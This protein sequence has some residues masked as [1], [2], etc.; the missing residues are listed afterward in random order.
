M[1]RRPIAFA[2][3]L[4]NKLHIGRYSLGE[5]LSFHSRNAFY[6]PDIII[7]KGKKPYVIIELKDKSSHYK[8]ILNK[9]FIEINRA[10]EY[11]KIEWSIIAINENE[12]YLRRLD[13]KNELYFNIDEIIDIIK[14]SV[15]NNVLFSI[16][17]DHIKDIKSIFDSAI[18]QLSPQQQN[19]FHHFL[20]NLKPTDFI[21]ENE[22]ICF[23]PQKENDFFKS[24]LVPVVEGDI[25]RYTSSNSLFTLLKSCN[26]NMLSLNCMN[27]ISE[28]DY[29]DKYINIETI[30]LDDNIKESNNVFILS[31][32]DESMSDD[33]MMWRLYAQNAEGV[34]LKYHI[35][36]KLI[37]YDYFYL[38][39]VSYGESP[40]SHSVLDFIQKLLEWNY[41]ETHFKFNKWM[42]WKHFFKSYHF[43]YENEVR[44]I[45]HEHD[46]SRATDTIWIED[47]NSGIYS[48]M[49]LFDIKK[50]IGS[51]FPLG[52]I[53]IKLGP[54]NK[55]AIINRIQ[56]EAMYDKANIYCPGLKEEI[57]ISNIDIYR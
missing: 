49:K 16:E 19:T 42:I 44:L 20:S 26:Q 15:N 43:R 2:Q 4:A 38:A 21:I 53:G 50:N 37:D 47:K 28:I 46:E 39:K 14:R 17:E 52:L 32:C 12:F 56:I 30:I 5:T 11:F 8:R 24:L 55:E 1:T 7:Y 23:T 48:P 3:E 41:N 29:A 57:N 54:R 34:N 9:F 25:C 6:T 27:D 18:T 31:C 45:Y 22:H 13:G 51:K 36:K 35:Y 10:Q 33:L 40:D